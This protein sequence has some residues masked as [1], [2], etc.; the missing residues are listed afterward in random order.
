MS[1]SKPK[2]A[3]RFS[4]PE[5]ELEKFSDLELKKLERVVADWGIDIS[6]VIR[7]YELSELL[8]ESPGGEKAVPGL[9]HDTQTLEFYLKAF[10][11]SPTGK[12]PALSYLALTFEDYQRTK[13]DVEDLV[14]DDDRKD[15]R[16]ASILAEFYR[17]LEIYEPQLR[18][19]KIAGLL[20]G[21]LYF[22]DPSNDPDV[23]YSLIALDAS[24]NPK[25]IL[26]TISN[27]LE[28]LSDLRI[29]CGPDYVD[30]LEKYVDDM[31]DH[32][33]ERES[34]TA[35]DIDILAFLSVAEPIPL[36]YCDSNPVL[37]R[38]QA[39]RTK[40]DQAAQEDPVFR[41]L[42]ISELDQVKKERTLKDRPVYQS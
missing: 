5:E 35:D 28:N 14:L 37:E 33:Y 1:I 2:L 32:R 42:I 34:M 3:E 20:A 17:E 19:L 7:D 16:V 6:R 41:A 22:G 38:I 4:V 9:I 36:S 10:Y 27:E 15:P 18:N 21:S 31:V 11:E 23:D 30:E 29:E 13:T 40:I 26:G 8:F 12:R 24:N 39:L 25:G